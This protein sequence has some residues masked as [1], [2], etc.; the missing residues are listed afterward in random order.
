MTAKSCSFDLIFHKV[1]VTIYAINTFPSVYYQH[2]KV[3]ARNIRVWYHIRKVGQLKLRKKWVEEFSS[4][5]YSILYYILKSQ[6]KKSW[7]NLSI[8]E[9]PSRPSSLRNQW[10]VSRCVS[11]ELT[12][13]LSTTLNELEERR[14]DIFVNCLTWL[15]LACK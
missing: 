5:A 6:Q 3:V 1:F 12:M 15:K 7:P 10:F 14:T 11:L 13:L 2:G 8:F 9:V 4:E